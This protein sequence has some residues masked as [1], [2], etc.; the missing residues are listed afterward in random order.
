MT[1]LAKWQHYTSRLTAPNIYIDMGF[2][3]L[4]SQSL[5]RRVWYGGSEDN[6]A[7]KLYPNMYI[8]FVG[9]PAVGK[10]TVITRVR[11]LLQFHKYEKGVP[12]KTSIGEEKPPLFC[13]GA[14]SL[15]F[16]ELLDDIGRSK[17]IMLTA[18][19]KTYF[20]CSYG[21]CIE[22]LDSLLTKKAEQVMRFLKNGFDCDQYERRTKHQGVVLLR[23]LCVNLLAGTQGDFF[24]EAAETGLF[25]QG[26]A[27]RSLWIFQNRPRGHAFHLGEID[28]AQLVSKKDLQIWLLH[29]SQL[30]GKITY[31][32]ECAHWLEDWHA[33]EIAPA[34]DN[35]TGRM[36]EWYGRK[37]VNMQK[38]AAAMHFGESLD[39]EMQQ[40][41]FERAIHVVNE[42]EKSL[43]NGFSAAGR[44][45]LHASTQRIQSYI[46]SRATGASRQSII[47]DFSGDLTMAE[48]DVCLQELKEGHN[49]REFNDG[50]GKPIYKL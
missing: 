34:L 33:R 41:T 44:N 11:D 24:R 39:L 45:V 35:A 19:K 49:L 32:T 1:N 16:E 50:N 22:E 20:H 42:I 12:I 18:D 8:V 14:D 15:T 27:S 47:L 36:A 38:I 3:A 9:P 30:Y 10:S 25:G 7:G 43:S 37:K 40:P 4:I 48:I 6:E 26:F 23:R 29:L 31:S 21:F 17:R 46:R 2:Y 28:E 13:L 5:Q